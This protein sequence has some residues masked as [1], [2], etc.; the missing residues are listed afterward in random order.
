MDYEKILL[1]HGAGG[2]LSS[3]L[4][5]RKFLPLFSNSY[6]KRMEDSAVLAIGKNRLCFTTD[7]YV[8]NPIFFPGGDIGS[9][10]V[11]G[12]VN[13]LSVCGAKP[14]FLSTGFILEEG[15]SM[16]DL[17][18][19]IKSMADAAK[20][21]GV[22]IVTGDTKVVAKGAADK[23]FINTS[24][25][26]AIEYKGNISTSSIMPGDVVIVNG[27]IGDHG[28]AILC[29]REGL[30]LKSEI[31]SDSAP[32]AS[33]VQKI[34]KASPNIHCM[35]D[36]TRGGLGA[37]LAEIS[38]QSKTLINV[39]EAAIPV[40][41]EVR[42]ICEILGLDPLYIANEGKLVVF[43]AE[44][45]AA[46]VL[47]AMKKHAY[48]KNAAIVGKVEKKSGAGRVIMKTVIGGSREIDL[49]TGELV[50]RIC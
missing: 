11:H 50:P 43:C 35:R 30:G 14:L 41:D 47:K 2:F 45:D 5:A 27:T 22:K 31:L 4:I 21:A 3:E 20:K 7:S 36:A 28:A 48:G 46:K 19:I 17:E 44:K 33:L 6:L 40:R 29:S 24:G 9:L 39:D 8:V 38:K 16:T 34:L 10:A 23:I 32:L 49:P 26:G 13:D 37:I 25:V 42:G 1:S 18:K 12:T 15:F